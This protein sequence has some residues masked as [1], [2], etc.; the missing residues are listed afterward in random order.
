MNIVTKV[1]YLSAGLALAVPGFSAPALAQQANAAASGANVMVIPPE[2]YEAIDAADRFLIQLCRGVDECARRREDLKAF[3]RAY[4]GRSIGF[5]QID[6]DKHTAYDGMRKQAIAESDAAAA[7]A[8]PHVGDGQT[9]VD[10]DTTVTSIPHSQERRGYFNTC[11]GT[12]PDA[13]TYI[14]KTGGPDLTEGIICTAPELERF[15]QQNVGVSAAGSVSF[16]TPDAYSRAALAERL[17]ALTKPSMVTV[18]TTHAGKRSGVGPGFAVGFSKAGTCEIA[19]A[20]HVVDEELA[21]FEVT[22]ANG[23]SYPATKALDK[24][25]HEVSII[26]AT[27]PA[28]ACQPLK[29]AAVPAAVG[30]QVFMGT[31]ALPEQFDP[32]APRWTRGPSDNL[33]LV[34]A[35]QPFAALPGLASRYQLGQ[36]TVFEG[37]QGYKA[38]SGTPGVNVDG[39]VVSMSFVTQEGGGVILAVPA[40]FITEA[41]DELHRR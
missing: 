9:H 2:R 29:F 15:L 16:A 13:V 36:D 30:Q 38:D 11:S 40:R 33:G 24:R 18:W 1:V 26:T 35:V 8:G 31:M 23:Q 14:L 21:E 32:R 39:E 28:E 10:G 27:V 12:G 41:L 5:G 3:A 7:K 6:L 17:E 22:M 25:E 37:I 19:T 34:T 20:S 4:L